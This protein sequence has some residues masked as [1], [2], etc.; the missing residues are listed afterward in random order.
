[1]NFPTFSYIVFLISLLADISFFINNDLL[2]FSTLKFTSIF[3]FFLHIFHVIKIIK[4]LTIRFIITGIFYMILSIL[5]LNA[6]LF[7]NIATYQFSIHIFTVG[8]M[9][10]LIIGVLFTW[11]P[12]LTMQ[13]LN[14]NLA[15]KFYYIYQVAI[16][17]FFVAFFVRDYN[18]VFF[19]GLVLFLVVLFYLYIIYDSVFKDKKVIFLPVVVKYFLSGW[20]FFLF[21]ILTILSIILLNR[22][23]LILL[24]I[25]FMVYGFGFLILSG[26]ILHLVPR[27]IW[28]WFYQEKVKLGKNVPS[29]HELVN[30][31]F[32][33][34]FL[35]FFPPF[36]LFVVFLDFLGLFLVSVS[37]MFVFY[38][39][40]LILSFYKILKFVFY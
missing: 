28:N 15:N 38:V 27:I 26:A 21:G 40:F 29:I 2:I 25:D 31:K 8:V 10:N 30:E 37:L 33:L 17:I 13:V 6:Y 4:P 3:A 35:Y 34:T 7:W 19:S 16:F 9:T 20:I 14:L 36:L 5:F 39:C 11:I 1:M 24:H 22:F 12:M 32:A 18:L 23:D